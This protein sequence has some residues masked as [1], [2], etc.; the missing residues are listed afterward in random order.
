MSLISAGS[1]SLDSTFNSVSGGNN[2]IQHCIICR[3]LD[4]TVTE[5]ARIEPISATLAFAVTG[6]SF[7]TSSKLGKSRQK[8]NI[9]RIS[10]NNRGPP[11]HSSTINYAA[12]RGF[13]VQIFLVLAA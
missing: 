8:S 2:Y 11:L 3:T 12:I 5:D 6:L 1:I 13:L 10:R 4:S 7:Q 9:L